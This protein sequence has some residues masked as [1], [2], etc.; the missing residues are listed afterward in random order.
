[1]MNKFKFGGLEKEGLY[2]DETVRRMCDTHRALFVELAIRLIY[3]GKFEKAKKVLAKMEEVLPEYNVPV[4]F[5][6]QGELLIEAYSRVGNKKRATEIAD[7]LWQNSIEWLDW[8][9]AQG[10]D[11]ILRYFAGTNI[12]CPKNQLVDERYGLVAILGTMQTV[13]EKWYNEHIIQYNNYYQIFAPYINLLRQK[14]DAEMM[15]F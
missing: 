6:N 1:M 13:D 11:Y 14:Q 12:N 8:Y 7:K 2:L 3:E 5:S 15:S 9:I 10:N 4:S